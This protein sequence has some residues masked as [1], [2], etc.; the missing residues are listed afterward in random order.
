MKQIKIIT[1]FSIALS[2]IACDLEPLPT[3]ATSA[4]GFYSDDSQIEAGIINI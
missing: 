4:N 3:A 2:F 1:I